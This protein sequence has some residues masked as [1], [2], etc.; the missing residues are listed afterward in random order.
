VSSAPNLSVGGNFL[1]EK[2]ELLGGIHTLQEMSGRAEQLRYK[3]K[4]SATSPTAAGMAVATV[5]RVAKKCRRRDHL[6]L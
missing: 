4:P 2:E 5:R 6:E 3:K 1:S